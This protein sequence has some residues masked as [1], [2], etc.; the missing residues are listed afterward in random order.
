M[1]VIYLL[2]SH[3]LVVTVP[4]PSMLQS[5]FQTLGVVDVYV[6]I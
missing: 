4:I 1:Q 3:N 2:G 6:H 5:E